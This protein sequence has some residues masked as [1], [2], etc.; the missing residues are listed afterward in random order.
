DVRAALTHLYAIDREL[1]RGGMATVYLARDLKHDRTVALK[2]LHRELAAALGA[3]R[4]LREIK[5]AAQLNHPHILPLFDSGSAGEFIYYTMPY[6]AGE[7]LRARLDRD[8]PLPVDEAIHHTRSIASALDYAHRQGII[9]RDIKPE[10]IMLHEGEAMVMD[11]GIAKALSVAGSD[12]ITQSG[13]MIGTPAY[14]SPEQASG[15]TIDARTDQYSLACVLYEMLSGERPFTGPTAQAVIARRLTQSVKPIRTVRPSVPE[16]VERALTTATSVSPDDRYAS[17]MDFASALEGA[18]P[19]TRPVKKWIRRAAAALVVLFLSTAGYGVFHGGIPWKSRGDAVESIA[20]MP[21][22]NETRDANGEF[23][24]DGMTETLITSLSQ[25]PS[26]K[27]KARSSVFRYKGRNVTPLTVGRELGVQAVLLG[28]VTQRADE[29]AVSLELVDPRNENVIWS[30][31]YDRHSADVVS[32][33][34]EIAQD[35]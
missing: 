35:V 9:H 3:D 22:V 24:S 34:S 10:N 17:A 6:V 30:Q 2:V 8:G 32:L 15:D 11:F 20:V 4:F 14:V 18:P 26:L 33:Q 7:S 29:L 1:A 23:L 31:R 12:T 16:S 25:L 19:A 13:V 5:L 27:V 21:F 28:R